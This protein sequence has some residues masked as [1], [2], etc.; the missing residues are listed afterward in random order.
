[1]GMNAPL[2]DPFARP[3]SYLRISVTD[4]CDFRCVYCMAEHMTFLPKAELLTLEELDR[5]C[6][7]FVGLGVQKLRV[8][9]G[10]PLVRRGILTFFR[11]MSRHLETG[12]L[13]ELTLTTNGSQLRRF[14]RDLVDCGVRRVN[15]SLDTLDDA[16]FAAVTRWGRLPQVLD[17]IAAAKEAG[18]RVK[19]NAVALKGFNEDEQFTLTDWCAREGHDLTWIEVMPMGDLGAEDR[20]DQYWPLRDLRDRY[21]ARYTLADLAERTGG[22]AR[23]V[24]LEET[25]QK[26]G[27]ITPL[28]HNFCESCNRVRLTCTG[29]L[30]MCLGQEDMAD[31]RAPLRASPD[32]AALQAAIRAAIARKPKGHDFDYSR[33]AVAGQMSRHMSHT[34]G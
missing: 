26:I 30:Y 23:Y 5:L 29:E 1:M 19:I 3:I 17:G 34:G 18:L 16:K 13:Q 8:T 24:R 33:Q 31:L 2:I 28:T 7:T 20:L 22:P 15:V 12:A 9:G 25:G 6:S 27:F 10:E 32:D 21:A 4:R 11:A 14:A